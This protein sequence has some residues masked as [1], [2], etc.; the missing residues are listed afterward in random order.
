[1]LN[2]DCFKDDT[3]KI[4]WVASFL[5]RDGRHVG[6]STH[7][8]DHCT[9]TSITLSDP[10]MDASSILMISLKGIDHHPP[11]LD[12]HFR[13]VPFSR[14]NYMSMVKSWPEHSK[15]GNH[16]RMKKL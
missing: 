12:F 3:Q 7:R 2:V 11:D 13:V 8:Q 15:E 16:S 10:A 4:G 5:G 14:R 6:R 9:T 1:M